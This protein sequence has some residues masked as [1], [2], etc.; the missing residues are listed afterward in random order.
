M[1]RECDVDKKMKRRRD[2]KCGARG[3][4]L[5]ELLVYVLELILPHAN[6]SDDSLWSHCLQSSSAIT[7]ACH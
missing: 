3:S 5:G 2:G 7:I 6:A 4:E 1:G